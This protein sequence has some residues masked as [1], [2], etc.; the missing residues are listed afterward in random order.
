[1]EE[2]QEDGRLKK[3]AKF[4]ILR[5]FLPLILHPWRVPNLKMKRLIPMVDYPWNDSRGNIFCRNNNETIDTLFG[6]L[7]FTHAQKC[8]ARKKINFF[9]KLFYDESTKKKCRRVPNPTA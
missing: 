3:R 4:V 5:E 6:A 2:K 7:S 8:H 1:M 9:K